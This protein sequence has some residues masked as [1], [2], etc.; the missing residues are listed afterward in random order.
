[1]IQ[2]LNSVATFSGTSVQHE[3]KN[4]NARNFL[5]AARR[6]HSAHTAISAANGNASGCR[7]WV[8]VDGKGIDSDML[9]ESL[10]EA[11]AMLSRMAK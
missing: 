8:E 3:W 11:Q 6:R 2:V 7:T 1:M 4:T 10:A 5:A 9:P